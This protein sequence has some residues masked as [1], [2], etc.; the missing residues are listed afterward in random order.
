VSITP[1]RSNG[2]GKEVLVLAIEVLIYTTKHLTTIF[3]SKADS[4]GYLSLLS[5][6]PSQTS[7]IRSITTT[8]LEYLIRHKQKQHVRLV[9]TLFARVK[10]PKSMFRMT[11]S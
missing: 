9:L 2:D 5:L 4:T 3:V 6:P 8:F 1:K 11:V 10:T 7:P